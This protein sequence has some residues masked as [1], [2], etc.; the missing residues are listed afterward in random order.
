MLATGTQSLLRQVDSPIT[1]Y[2]LFVTVLVIYGGLAVLALWVLYDGQQSAIPDS[3][4][5]NPRSKRVRRAVTAG[6]RELQQHTDPRQS[7][8]ACYARLEH[9]LEDYGVPTYDHLTAQEYMGAAMQGVDIPLDAF[10]SLV[11]LFEQA[12][13]SLH[14]LDNAAREQAINHLQTIKSHLEWRAALATST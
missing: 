3:E 7:I 12:R 11:G 9:L 8:I 2:A 14:P 4:S 10:A 13:Y 1:G 5:E 6:R